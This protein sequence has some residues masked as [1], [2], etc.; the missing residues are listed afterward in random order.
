MSFSPPIFLCIQHNTTIKVL[1][2]TI[3]ILLPVTVADGLR[4]LRGN[5]TLTELCLR[6]R[7]LSGAALS[8]LSFALEAHP[9]SEVQ[10][11]SGERS[12]SAERSAVENYSDPE[13]LFTDSQSFGLS[14][15][16]TLE[17]C[18]QEGEEI[19]SR[20]SAVLL[21]KVLS[22]NSHVP[23]HDP[24][25]LIEGISGGVANLTVNIFKSE[26]V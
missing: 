2:L 22:R 15:L 23:L 7:S 25:D 16:S 17:Y 11:S 19:L 10:F 3:D 5:S 9:S 21:E 24:I 1:I 20:L 14:A 26:S 18:L 4:F 13:E 12:S 8:A 6:G